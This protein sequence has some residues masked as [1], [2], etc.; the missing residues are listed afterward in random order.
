LRIALCRIALRSWRD[1]QRP[2]GL[3]VGAVRAHFSNR[4]HF[5]A[6]LEPFDPVVRLRSPRE[7]ESWLA[8]PR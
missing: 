2:Y 1:G 3:I 6:R 7:V 5:P 8:R 4:R